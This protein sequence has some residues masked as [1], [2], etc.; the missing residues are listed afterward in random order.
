MLAA[1]GITAIG[2]TA[3]AVL[4]VWRERWR[5]QRQHEYKGRQQAEAQ[6]HGMLLSMSESSVSVGGSAALVAQLL[7]CCCALWLALFGVTARLGGVASHDP[8]RD[9]RYQGYARLVALAAPCLTLFSD[10][11][12]AMRLLS[13]FAGL[14]PVYILL[15]VHYEVLFICTLACALGCW[16]LVE[17]RTSL[18]ALRVLP[19]KALAAGRARP[20]MLEDMRTALFFLLFINV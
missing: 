8:Q 18:A 17:Q 12:F 16:V 6:T 11:H 13:I 5:Q 10:R 15:S 9:A 14:V 4:T 3:L 20:L 19:R 7:L 2:M 1:G